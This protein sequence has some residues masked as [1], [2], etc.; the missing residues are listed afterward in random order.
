MG[1]TGISL[2]THGYPGKIVSFEPLAKCHAK[3]LDASRN[4]PDWRI[5]E[6]CA[7]GDRNGEIE[8]AMSEAS[9]LSSI[10]EPTLAMSKA[11]PKVRPV[12]RIT[13]PIFRLDALTIDELP[14]AK[15]PFLKIDA[16]GYDLAV[17][18][19]CSGIIEKILG[20]QVEMSLVQLYRDEPLYLEIL[21]FLH[22]AGFEPHTLVERGFSN[23]LGRQLQIDGVF[24]RGE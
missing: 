17:L 18:R 3:L 2:R 12:E 14:A 5:H 1:Q 23:E 10:G 16:Q 22:Q 20:V 19:G 15:A 4:D 9:D 24:M 7:L 13:V 21:N 8:I 11:L 6:P